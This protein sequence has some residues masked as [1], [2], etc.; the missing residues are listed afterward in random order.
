VKR[1]VRGSNRQIIMLPPCYSL[2]NLSSV[3]F[4]AAASRPG[5]ELI[6]FNPIVALP[7]P[8]AAARFPSQCKDIVAFRQ[9]T[10]NR[11]ERVMRES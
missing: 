5:A 1:V 10:K 8:S 3:V 6:G 11:D 9:P 4:V 2:T 7:I